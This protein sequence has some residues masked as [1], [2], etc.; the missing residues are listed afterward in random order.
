[1]CLRQA[2]KN[3]CHEKVNYIK[4]ILT[5]VRTEVVI[6]FCNVIKRMDI[7]FS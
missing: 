1:M 4:V 7:C 2:S 3:L 6:G 5:K